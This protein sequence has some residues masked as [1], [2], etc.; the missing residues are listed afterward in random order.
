MFKNFREKKLTEFSYIRFSQLYK[1]VG[2]L[3]TFW[4]AEGYGIIHKC[5]H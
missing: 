2:I 3:L 5:S 4:I 1:S